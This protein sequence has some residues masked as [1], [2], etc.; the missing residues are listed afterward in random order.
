MAAPSRSGWR[1]SSPAER[2]GRRLESGAVSADEVCVQHRY[3]RISIDTARHRIAGTVTLAADGYRSR[4]S[5]LLNAPERD[6]IALSDATVLELDGDRQRTS[7]DFIAVHRDHVVFA[8]PL[9]AV[10]VPGR[11]RHRR[12]TRA[13]RDLARELERRDEPDA[14]AAP[15][16]PRVIPARRPVARQQPHVLVRRRDELGAVDRLQRRRSAHAPVEPLPREAEARRKGA[17]VEALD[18]LHEPVLVPAHRARPAAGAP[19]RA[20]RTSRSRSR[21]PRRGGAAGRRAG[22]GRSTRRAASGRARRATAAA[23]GRRARRPSR[24]G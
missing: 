8:V 14:V 16:A 15:E 22:A 5:D 17:A 6:F 12:L 3:V 4:L 21:R 18:D 23:A 10:E 7:H 1:R 11:H 13:H 19:T 9:G 20:G 24:R 2:N